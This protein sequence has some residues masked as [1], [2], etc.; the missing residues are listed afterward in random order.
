MS[1]LLEITEKL[2]DTQAAIVHLE[3]AAASNPDS[4]SIHLSLDSLQKRQRDLEAQLAEIIA[5]ERKRQRDVEARLA[6][7]LPPEQKEYE[8]PALSTLAKTLHDFQV[9]ATQ[10]FWELQRET[11]KSTTDINAD[12]ILLTVMREDSG[13]RESRIRTEEAD[14]ILRRRKDLLLSG[15]VAAAIGVA[16]CL[17]VWAIVSEGSSELDKTR[18]VTF[19]TAIVTGLIGYVTGRATK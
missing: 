7:I 4:T 19:L 2:Q 14:A 6:K 11:L 9:L 8:R 10:V 17:C 18:A 13:E 16:L 15:S 5:A 1:V 12:K 3:N